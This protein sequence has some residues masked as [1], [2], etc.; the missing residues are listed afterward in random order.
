MNRIRYKING[1]VQGVGFRP[2]IYKL[3][4]EL[5]VNGYVQNISS[6]VVIDI[7][8]SDF[9][10]FEKVLKEQLPKLAKIDMI[11]KEH[12]ELLNYKNFVIKNSSTLAKSHTVISADIS[13][14]KDCLDDIKSSN[15]FSGYFAT[16]CTSCGPRYSIINSLPYDRCNTTMNEFEMCE[17]CKD[18]YNDP[19]NRRFHAQPISCNKCGPKLNQDI[20]KIAQAIKDAKI[21][22][23][24]SIGGYNLVCDAT[25]D[26]VVKRLRQLKNRPSKPFAVMISSDIDISSIAT[27]NELE[28]QT[29]YNINSPILIANKSSDYALSV[30]VAPDIDRVGL[31]M[32]YN[33]L[34]HLLFEHIKFPIVTTSA[35]MSGSPII[36]DEESLYE[37]LGNVYDEV[38][39][40]DRK[41]ENSI[42]DSIVQIV[43]DKMIFLRYARGYA[44][45]SMLLKDSSSK[46]ILAF[47]AN[48]KVTISLVINEH[49][50]TSPYIADLNSLESLEAYKKVLRFFCYIYDFKAD[51]VVCDKH[52]EYES[53]K[54]AYMYAK[55]NG[56]KLYT[57]QH[58]YAHILSVMAQLQEKKEYL[59]F[60]FDG[61]GK[62]D[63]DNI[64]GG[65]VFTCND[66]TYKRV[67]HFKEF[68][69]LGASKAIKE[70]RRVAL[71]LLFE[72]FT[73]E[74]I[75]E[76]DFGVLKYFS[77]KEL[78][79]LHVSYKNGIN[80]PKTTSLGRIFDG[81]A[82]LSNLCHF[83]SYEGESGLLIESSYNSTCKETLE[84]NINDGIINIDFLSIFKDKDFDISIYP[85]LFLNTIVKI[86]I[87][88][89]KMFDKEIIFSG[90]VFQ[91]KILL[92][93]II[94]ELKKEKKIFHLNENSSPNDESISIGQ[95]YWAYT[96][97][98]VK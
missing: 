75:K 6:G 40:H 67:F 20:K 34:Q 89:S 76:S 41:I 59:A 47:G 29:L 31:L 78:E 4:K 73:L 58:H 69:L 82:S 33:P 90:G 42:D 10:L 2:F 28:I 9:R 5:N 68:R 72:R 1:I 43:D 54:L 12:L 60:A 95:A 50:I 15:R 25:N 87:D 56:S 36:T 49:I 24:K 93:A 64:W 23:I 86:V 8:S 7:E 26:E 45:S 63:D 19:E 39:S 71:S 37:M 11:E 18:E 52:E 81:V 21:V 55:E 16:N 57:L 83:Q 91:N 98:G 22:A 74:Q 32:A 13:T 62:G 38:L 92:D 44:P 80:A 84:Y 48:Q 97:H 30:H 65:E 70:P 79:L 66:K 27:L 94:K 14:C 46:K 61:T 96:N 3:A 51:I 85:T 35:N 88:I 53:T 77:E 17:D